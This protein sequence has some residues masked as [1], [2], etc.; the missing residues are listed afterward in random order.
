MAHLLKIW[1]RQEA[2]SICVATM[3]R[4]PK[5]TL[6]EED[7][8]IEFLAMLAKNIDVPSEIQ[9]VSV[10]AWAITGIGHDAPRAYNWLTVLRL[11]KEE[12]GRDLETEFRPQR[13]LRYWRM[14]DDILTYAIIESS[15]LAS[16]MVRA[17]LLEQL[18]TLR[19]RQQA[20]EQSKSSFIAVAA[21]ELKTPLTIL[22]GYANMLRLE[23][24]KGSRLHIYVDGLGNG[25]RRMHEVIGDMIDVSLIDLD[26]VELNYRE[27]NLEKI[28]LLVADSVDRFFA[29]RRV[30][31]VIMPFY[32]QA[33]TFGDEEKIAKALTKIVMNGLKYTPD[34]GQV[35]ISAAFVRQDEATDELAGY[36]D[37]QISDTG[38]G[39]APEN[40]DLVF[41][42]FTSLSDPSLHSSSKTKFKGGGPGLGL[43]IAKGIVEAH[44]GCV[45]AES[46]GCDEERCPGS[47]FHIEIPV[48]LNKP[49]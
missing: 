48:L 26:S 8:L 49:T 30:E 31:L 5:G 23:S 7:D 40:L 25:F 4:V 16:D 39:I 46:P 3:R 28:V 47:T 18:I 19:T 44:A 34:Y 24:E 14:L 11:L 33:T 20:F 45:W 43:A 37:I 1:L 35:T 27:L 12:I 36:L 42:N 17:D 29:E 10:Q 9:L 13:T 21:H 32:V 6:I 15:Q 38:I 22:E 2:A 41:N